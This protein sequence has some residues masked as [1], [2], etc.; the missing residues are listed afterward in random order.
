[1]ASNENRPRAVSN[2]ASI[3][4][5]GTTPA[6]SHYH[7]ARPAPPPPPPMNLPSAPPTGR[8]AAETRLLADLWLQSAATFRR[9]GKIEQA[10]G[11]IQEA[12]V[13]DPSNPEVWVQ[14][15]ANSAFRASNNRRLIRILDL[16]S[17]VGITR[18]LVVRSLPYRLLAKLSYY[19]RN[20]LLPLSEWLNCTWVEISLI[21]RTDCLTH[22]RREGAGTLPRHG[23]SSARSAR[24]KAAVTSGRKSAC[25]SRSNS[26]RVV[27]VVLWST[28][29]IDGFEQLNEEYLTGGSV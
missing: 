27:S 28:L 2:G 21:S 24:H 14:V 16:H 19:R 7:G 5:R 23:I 17:S 10:L 26:K 12:E 25:C 13:M 9:S 3:R 4:S 29:S 1:M 11:A 22:S 8:N 15:S 20:M 18:S 6:H